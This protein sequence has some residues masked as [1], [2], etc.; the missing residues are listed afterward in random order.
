MREGPLASLVASAHSLLVS[1]TRAL[2]KVA[3]DFLLCLVQE[4]AAVKIKIDHQIA[5]NGSSGGGKI[6]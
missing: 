5:F 2:T 4:D 1:P 6:W 3:W